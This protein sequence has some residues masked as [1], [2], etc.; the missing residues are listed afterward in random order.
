MAEPTFED[1]LKEREQIEKRMNMEKLMEEFKEDM[2]RKK[3]MEQKQMASEPD[4]TDSRNELALELFG[5]ELKLLT[6]EEMDI[7]DAEAERLMQKFMADGGR[8]SKQTGGITESRVLPPE[9][10]EA[11]QKTFLAD[12][13]RTW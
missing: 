10:L 3:V 4:M 12:L 11:A 7:L 2:R 8:V 6:P 5:K 13:T 1:Y 9:F